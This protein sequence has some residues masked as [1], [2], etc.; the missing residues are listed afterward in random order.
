MVDEDP[1]PT[2]SGEL[3]SLASV[4]LLESKFRVGRDS[5][6]ELASDGA[7]DDVEEPEH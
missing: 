3:R 5:R 6:V 1:R 7:L 2:G 4:V